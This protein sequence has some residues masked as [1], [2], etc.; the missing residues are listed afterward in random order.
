M[1]G[2]TRDAVTKNHGLGM[3]RRVVG[4]QRGLL[5]STEVAHCYSVRSVRRKRIG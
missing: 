2:V 3:M 4:W 1:L 5:S